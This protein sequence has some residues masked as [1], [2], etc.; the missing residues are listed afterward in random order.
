VVKGHVIIRPRAEADLQRAWHH[1]ELEQPGLGDEFLRELRQLIQSLERHPERAAF[2]YRG[3]R[4]LL[5]TRFPYKVFYRIVA[6]RVI[7]FR[8]LHTKQD[9][10]RRLS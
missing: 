10:P 2:Y 9:H 1:Y 5:A 4:R 3:F 7:V 8:V 6:D